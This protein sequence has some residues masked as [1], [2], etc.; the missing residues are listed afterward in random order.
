MGQVR[1]EIDGLLIQAMA[2]LEIGFDGSNKTEEDKARNED[3]MWAAHEHV[4]R[5][6]GLNAGHET[7]HK[8]SNDTQIVVSTWKALNAIAD[9]SYKR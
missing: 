9:A 4:Q 7:P 8:I 2:F 1:A 6:W 5:A 3:L